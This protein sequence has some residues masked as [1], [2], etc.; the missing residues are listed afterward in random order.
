MVELLAGPLVGAA[1]SDKLAEKNWGNLVL[2]LDPSLLG[3]PELIKA[4]MS[5]VLERVRSAPRQPGVSEI[6]LPGERGNR[7]AATRVSAGMVPIEPNM[8]A[9]LRVMAAK[10]G[11]PGG[12]IGVTSSGTAPRAGRD[13]WESYSVAT[14]LV[15]GRHSIE[16][17]YNSSGPPLWQT[18]TFAQPTSTTN[19]PYDYTR[20]GNPTRDMLQ[21][22][23]AALE[24]ADRALAF[25]SGMAALAAVAKLA[26]VGEHIVAGED[27]YGGTSRLL[28]M[29]VPAAGVS[30]T[31]VDMSDVEK[32]R[33]A[34]IPGK[35]KLV[36][37]ESPTNPRMQICDIRAICAAARAA[38]AVTC[39]DNS[40]MCPTFQRPLDLG[41]DISMTSGTK[42]IGG[43]ADVTLGILS[44]KVG[45]RRRTTW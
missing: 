24:G 45:V 38:G 2:A 7:L 33:R 36:M 32:V 25:T 19:G 8:L 4:R 5:A 17:P 31:N 40:I 35:T 39:V 26:G 21:E 16:D 18:A 12:P 23:M 1:V 44:I 11:A 20:S 37:I 6:L 28:S 9:S 13:A 34:I 22:Q 3:N 27:L 42:F 29:V 10:F 43:H 14:K 41:A 15:H 30:V